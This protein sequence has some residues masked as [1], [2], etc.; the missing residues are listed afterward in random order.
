MSRK[1]LLTATG[2]AMLAASVGTG[3][4]GGKPVACYERYRTE[5]VY[6]TVYENVLVSPASRYYETVPAVYG[7]R[8]RAVLVTPQQVGYETVPALVRTQYR[9]V[10]VADGGYSWEWRAINGRKVLCKIR[11]KARYQRIAEQVVV[12]EAYR[13][14]VVI[15]AVYDYELEQVVIQP[16]YRRV[17]EVPASYRTVARRVLVSDGE[18]R[19]RRVRISRYCDG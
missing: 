7:T 16:E 10:K 5:P 17:V 3:F 6:D 11:H 18:T 1:V 15:P 2:L 4:A 13:R 8:K 19:W 12:R 14:R 9:T